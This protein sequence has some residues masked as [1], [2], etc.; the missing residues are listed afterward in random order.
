VPAGADYPVE[1]DGESRPMCC[2][3]CQAVAE[4]ICSM[5][6][7]DYYRHRTGMPVRPQQVPEFLPSTR[8]YDKDEIQR[9]FVSAMDGNRRE[10]ELIIEGLVC[11]ACAWLIESRISPL[12]GVSEMMVNFSDQRCRISWDQSRVRL[13]EILYRIRELG[14][15][16]QPYSKERQQAN[17]ASENRLLL[18]RIGVAGVFG[19]Q[20]MMIAIALYQ[21]EWSGMET[22]FRTFFH[23]ISLILCIPVLIYSA[24]PFFR[25]A[26]RDIRHLHPG[27][28]VSVALGLALAFAGSVR[29]TFTGEGHVYYESVAMFVFFL[30]LGRYFELSVRRKVNNQVDVYSRVVP[31][32][33][34][35]L[36]AGGSEAVAVVELA[37]GDSIRIK[38]GNTVPVDCRISHGESLVDESVISGESRPR[39]RQPG[40]ELMAGSVNM[41][42]VLECRVTHISS[43]SFIARVQDLINSALAGKSRIQQTSQRIASVFI[44]F[45]LLLALLTSWYWIARGADDWLAITV[46]VLIITCPCALALATPVAMTAMTG[47]LMKRGIL[48]GN[49]SVLEQLRGITHVVFDKTGTLTRGELT[50]ERIVPLAGED[51]NRCLQIAAALEQA[52]EHPLAR[53]FLAAAGTEQL[54]VASEVRNQ[55]GAGLVGTVEGRRYYLG[56]AVYIHEQTGRLPDED[57]NA[58][59]RIVLAD[60]NRLVA[61]FYFSDPLREEARAVIDAIRSRGLVAMVMS[62]DREAV[63]RDVCDTLAINQRYSGMRPGDKMQAVQQLRSAGHRVLMVGDGINDGPVL[64]AA[65]LSIAMGQGTDLVKNAADVIFL[66]NS[67]DNLLLLYDLVLRT[68]RII[69]QN[70]AWA[71]A[72]NLL[73]IPAAVSGMV[74]PWLAALGMSLSSLAVVLNSARLAR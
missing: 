40:D 55:P 33:A 27:M 67:L 28:D 36:I 37:V 39:P 31:M 53:A 18:R 60:D 51:T 38:P 35:R 44:V 13:S 62:G 42:S 54:P 56:S 45:I 20:I 74:A 68:S 41:D 46:S 57:N 23:G 49:R 7:A 34:E 58:H 43:D 71:I 65:D 59:T 66:N 2:A 3:G 29:T 12:P 22:Q 11:P 50:V 30:L 69:H 26:W 47:S 70:M 64:A 5:G 73:A 21:G 10:A 61:V 52:S 72:Y 4:T 19:M 1:I 32:L 25:G 63:V 48:T 6:L 17:L 14:Y 8:L 9:D 16:A 24:A 15:D